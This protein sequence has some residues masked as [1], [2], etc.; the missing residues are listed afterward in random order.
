MER[1]AN[2]AAGNQ[3]LNFRDNKGTRLEGRTCQGA[4]D[5]PDT[6]YKFKI[7]FNL[8]NAAAR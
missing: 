3:W 7:A 6:D 4:I 2:S 1:G 5:Q 8:D